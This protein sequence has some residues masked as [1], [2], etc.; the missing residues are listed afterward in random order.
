[1]TRAIRWI[2]SAGLLT[3]ALSG[4]NVSPTS[5]VTR[6]DGSEVTVSWAD[7]PATAWDDAEQILAGPPESE[8]E[9]RVAALFDEIR[10]TLDEEFDFRWTLEG[11]DSWYRFGGNGYGGESYLLLYESSSLVSDGVP[12]SAAD[13]D[14][15]I[16]R[17]SAVTDAYDLGRV[18][19]D[20]ES[21][22]P[23]EDEAWQKEQFDIFGTDDPDA[24]WSWSGRVFTGSERL[25]VE[26]TDVDRDPSGEAA[27]AYADDYAGGHQVQFSYSARTIP[28]DERDAFVQALKPFK[29]LTR[30]PESHPD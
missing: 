30:P 20:H 29:G 8:V 21:P 11:E 4:C 22:P 27:E 10:T 24:Y 5:T 7:Y 16:E 6:P 19:L 14:K 18:V 3:L 1:M 12:T 25:D 13:W 15:I 26:I 2:V 17:V 28:D 23:W 9:P